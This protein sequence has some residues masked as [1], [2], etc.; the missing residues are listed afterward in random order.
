ME[1][2][3]LR[4]HAELNALEERG[5]LRTTPPA[6]GGD[7][8]ASGRQFGRWQGDANVLEAAGLKIMV[9]NTARGTPQTPLSL[10]IV[11]IGLHNCSHIED[12]LGSPLMVPHAWGAVHIL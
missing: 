1:E 5:L 12:T 3:G 9:I 2:T 4:G 7:A 10:H 11:A 8:G 6:D